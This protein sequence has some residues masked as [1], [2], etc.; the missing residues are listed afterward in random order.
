[1]NHSHTSLYNLRAI[2]EKIEA[3]RQPEVADHSGKA[4]FSLSVM[5]RA[6]SS[7]QSKPVMEDSKVPRVAVVPYIWG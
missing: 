4:A 1:M 7:K 2:Q 3:S 5:E 6:R